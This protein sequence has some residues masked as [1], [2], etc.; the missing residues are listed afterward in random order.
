MKKILLFI[1][2]IITQVALSQSLEVSSLNARVQTP[3][4]DDMYMSPNPATNYITFSNLRTLK[5]RQIDIFSTLGK[6]SKSVTPTS[7]DKSL[8]LNISDLNSGVYIVRLIDASGNAIKRKL[9]VN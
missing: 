5:I 6:L 7:Y 4:Q 3:P 2:L 9:I 1:F 8:N